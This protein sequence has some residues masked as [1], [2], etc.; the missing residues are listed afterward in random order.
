MQEMPMGHQINAWSCW[1]FSWSLLHLGSGFCCSPVWSG[2]VT[3]VV[4]TRVCRPDMTV[5]SHPKHLWKCFPWWSSWY[6][7]VFSVT[8]CMHTIP[9]DGIYIRKPT[10]QMV[11]LWFFMERL[12]FPLVYSL[13]HT[14]P[15]GSHWVHGKNRR[16]RGRGAYR[17]EL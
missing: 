10:V 4:S 9:T 16:G 1:M 17:R 14:L 15:S 8:A 6:T 7:E 13:M 2:R 5:V 3:H 11:E 12:A